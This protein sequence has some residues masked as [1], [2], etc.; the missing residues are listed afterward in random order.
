L[1]S[2]RIPRPSPGQVLKALKR[3][4]VANV[5]VGMIEK[6]AQLAEAAWT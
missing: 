6:T 3:S 4:A 5:R 1:V 2:G